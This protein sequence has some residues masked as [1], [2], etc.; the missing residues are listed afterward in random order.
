VGY[1]DSG[2]GYL[3]TAAMLG[4]RGYEDS[5]FLGSFGLS[6]RF[7]PEVEQLVQEAW[8]RLTR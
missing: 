3:P 6:G 7:R 2:F 8:E 1:I 5:A 4:E